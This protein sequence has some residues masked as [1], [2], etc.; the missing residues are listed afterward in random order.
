MIFDAPSHVHHPIDS[1]EHPVFRKHRI[2]L[3]VCSMSVPWFRDSVTGVQRAYGS[4]DQ[5]FLLGLELSLPSIYNTVER[6]LLVMNS[7]T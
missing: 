7:R 6:S 5:T 3:E 4:E 1:C 2:N